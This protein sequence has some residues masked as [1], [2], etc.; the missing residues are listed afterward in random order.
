MVIL[1][2][3]G[4]AFMCWATMEASRLWGTVTVIKYYGIPWLLVTHWCVDMS[5]AVRALCSTVIRL[6]GLS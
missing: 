3:L 4:I 1:S 2:N 5:Y 6:A